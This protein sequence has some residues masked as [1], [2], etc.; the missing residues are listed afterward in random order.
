MEIE[1]VNLLTYK[2]IC[3]IMRTY[4]ILLPSFLT[5]PYFIRG[6]NF[7]M[8]A[9]PIVHIELSTVNGAESAKFYSELFG[10]QTK[11]IPE[12]NYWTFA[13]EGGPGGGFNDIGNVD[14]EAMG[15][16]VKPGTVV[17]YVASDD[18]EADLSRAEALGA[19]TL[20]TKME[21]PF[22]GW[23]GIFSD[24]SGNLIGLYT[25][26]PKPAEG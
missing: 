9:Q 18:I 7:T 10:W 15:L 2:N 3:A 17:T 12:V 16:L 21:I 24:P 1:A 4:S 20:T 6:D 5:N 22:T 25:E 19:K 13:A 11:H 14:S 8:A 26:M 23:F